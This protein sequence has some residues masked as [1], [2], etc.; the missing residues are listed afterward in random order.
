MYLNYGSK[1]RMMNYV[2]SSLPIF[3]LCSLKVYLWV[4]NKVD[5]Y[6]RHCL[7][8]D[9][10]LQTKPLLWQPGILFAGQKIKVAWVY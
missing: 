6:R 7:C 3:F 1:L 2:L 9:K 8:R 10:D 4:I 5:K